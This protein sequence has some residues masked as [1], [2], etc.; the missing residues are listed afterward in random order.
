MSWDK[1]WMEFATS[2]ATDHS[3]CESKQVACVIVK[4]GKPISIGYNGTIS[5]T[6]NCNELFEK[7]AGGQFKVRM[8]VIEDKKLYEEFL[9]VYME[10]HLDLMDLSAFISKLH[11]RLD[12]EGFNPAETHKLAELNSKLIRRTYREDNLGIS[13]HFTDEL[14][15][16]RELSLAKRTVKS[17]FEIWLTHPDKMIHHEWSKQNEVHAEINAL[18]KLASSAESAKGSTAYVT[19]SP[20]RNCALALIQSGVERVVFKES[21]SKSSSGDLFTMSGTRLE[22]FKV[23]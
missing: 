15:R 20:C 2:I 23:L 12:K 22:K 11:T 3:K 4:D 13:R 16:E 8:D 7:Q 14:K 5:G 17:L 1:T 19:L 10:T 21:Y 9:D 6:L 18:A